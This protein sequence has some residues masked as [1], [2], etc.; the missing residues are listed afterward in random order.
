MSDNHIGDV[1]AS[2]GYGK[3]EMDELA[4]LSFTKDR[5]HQTHGMQR[6]GD[7]RI[8]PRK[9]KLVCGGWTRL[10]PAGDRPSSTCCIKSDHRRARKDKYCS[11]KP[12]GSICLLVK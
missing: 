4:R 6:F 7:R 3:A 1:I 12:K 2:Y 5:F 10:T 11:A 9:S 8:S